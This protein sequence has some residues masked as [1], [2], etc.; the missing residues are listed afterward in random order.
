MT[1]PTFQVSLKRGLSSH[2]TGD[3]EALIFLHLVRASPLA[4]PPPPGRN[5]AETQFA[6]LLPSIRFARS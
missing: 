1:Q 3:F 2:R 4:P 5:I 6:L